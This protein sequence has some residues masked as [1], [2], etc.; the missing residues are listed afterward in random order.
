MLAGRRL[1]GLVRAEAAQADETGAAVS[2]AAVELPMMVN[3]D[4]LEG[5]EDAMR[6]MAGALSADG[7]RV[8]L[9]RIQVCGPKISAQLIADTDTLEPGEETTLRVMVMN[10]GLAGAQVQLTCALPTGLETTGEDAEKTGEKEEPDAS[11]EGAL[12]PAGDD[13]PSGPDGV[14]ALAAAKETVQRS[15]GENN[16]VIFSWYM[17]AAEESGEGVRANAQVLE[18]PVRALEAQEDLKERLV[19]AALA[20]SVDGGE[21]RFGEAVAMRVYTPSFLGIAHEDWNAIFWACVLMM[22][23][24]SCLYAAVSAGSAK[25]EY[26][27]E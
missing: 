14:P 18:I 19:G 16:T 24:V 2:L 22:I 20:Y 7:A 27:C 4:A 23:T 17:D 21:L 11:E 15:A 9:P 10:E 3:E 5:D 8:P 13:S 1:S 26:Y 6:L 12:L 25:D